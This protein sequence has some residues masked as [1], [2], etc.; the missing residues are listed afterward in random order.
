MTKLKIFAE[1]NFIPEEERILDNFEVAW[2]TT[3]IA[4]IGHKFEI[5]TYEKTGIVLWHLFLSWTW[6]NFKHC[7][8]L[9]VT[10]VSKLHG[11]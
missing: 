1:Q 6:F 8:W 9:T 5:Q 7:Y 11:V 3:Q 10:G 2:A 4:I